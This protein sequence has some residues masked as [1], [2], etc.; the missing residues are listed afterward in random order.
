MEYT[1]TGYTI[2]WNISDISHVA[3]IMGMVSYTCESRTE[4]KL[5]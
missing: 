5:E 4:A 2:L 1:C 3:I